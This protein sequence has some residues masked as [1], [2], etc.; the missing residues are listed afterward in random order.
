MRIL[1][2]RLFIKIID[3]CEWFSEKDQNFDLSLLNYKLKKSVNLDSKV[4]NAK[5]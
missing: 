3:G 4:Y 1:S 2:G 5:Y